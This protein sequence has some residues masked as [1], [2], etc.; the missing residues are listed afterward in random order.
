VLTSWLVLVQFIAPPVIMANELA[1]TSAETEGEEVNASPVPQLVVVEEEPAPSAQPE[2]GTELETGRAGTMA[3]SE[4]EVNT[5]AVGSSVE[6]ATLNVGTGDGD[7]TPFSLVEEATAAAELE[8][9]DEASDSAEV[10]ALETPATDFM[11]VE[12]SNEAEVE[13]ETTAQADTGNNTQTNETGGSTE[14]T[15]GDAVAVANSLALVNTTLVNSTLQVGVVNV[16]SAWDGDIIIDPMNGGEVAWGGQL[17]QIT[18]DNAG[19]IVVTTTAA[20]NTGNNS[21]TGGGEQTMQTG[22]AVALSSSSVIAGMTVVNADMLQLLIE[23]LW[24]W[25]GMI[26]NWEYPGSVTPASMING[27]TGKEEGCGSGCGPASLAVENNAEVTVTTKAEANTGNNTQVSTGEATM[28]TGNALA[29]ATSTVLVNTTLIN[30]RMTLLHFLL[31]D[32]WSGNLIFAYPDLVTTVTA[33]EEVIEGE[34]ITY[35]ISITNVGHKIAHGLNYQYQITN[36]EHDVGHDGGTADEL[37]PG[38]SITQTVNFPTTGRGGHMVTL[39]AS[40]TGSSTEVSTGNN[41]AK[42]ETMVISE[43]SPNDSSATQGGAG[44]AANQEVPNLILSGGNNAQNGVYPGDGIKNDWQAYNAG[45]ITAHEV[46]F[47]QEFYSPDGEIL[48]QV[49][50]PVGEIAL[51]NYR[52]ISFVMTPAADLKPGNFYTLSYLLGKSKEGAETKS[53]VVRSE[54]L[55]LSRGLTLV[56]EVQAAEPKEPDTEMVLGVQN[57]VES[58]TECQAIPWYL[59]VGLGSLAY[60]LVTR[61][62]ENFLQV[63]KWGLTL[64]IAGYAGLLLT[65]GDCR[66]GIMIVGAASMWCKWFLPIS[67]GLYGGIGIV[68][69]L[70]YR[71]GGN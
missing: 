13:V 11:K 19:N 27:V 45:P 32:E 35:T 15:T 44:L 61:R 33:P 56:G 24:L 65:A 20:A 1:T 38:E 60:F 10:E 55:L 16:M 39:V 66:Q 14:M 22:T 30:S 6:M 9:T 63:L 47:V 58:C 23:N 62:R 34:E 36:D 8:S 26:Y 37:I 43:Q 25:S 3:A 68:S 48:T 7:I 49:G 41:V 18:I 5:T 21:Q 64:P 4:N 29:S 67:Y 52:Y 59:G 46:I 69:R 50:G 40:V 12:I 53:N 2:V 54:V 31:F 42:V 71:R 17:E 51:S 28:K 70:V 57:E